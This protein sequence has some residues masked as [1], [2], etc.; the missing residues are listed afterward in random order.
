MVT[1]YQMGFNDGKA[2]RNK[3]SQVARSNSDPNALKD[4]Q[5][6]VRDGRAKRNKK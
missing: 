6:G 2:G 5:R 1:Y 4:Y 3:G